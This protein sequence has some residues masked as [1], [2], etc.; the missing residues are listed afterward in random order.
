MKID[1][2]LLRVKC[3]IGIEELRMKGCLSETIYFEEVM[4]DFCL[5]LRCPREKERGE[6]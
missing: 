4:R 5:L 6:K 1:C 3:E 2:C